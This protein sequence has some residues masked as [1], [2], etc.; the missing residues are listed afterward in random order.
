MSMDGM[1]TAKRRQKKSGEGRPARAAGGM[2][3]DGEGEDINMSGRRRED[4]GMSASA[5]SRFM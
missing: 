5:S 3:G 1:E 4:N 2:R